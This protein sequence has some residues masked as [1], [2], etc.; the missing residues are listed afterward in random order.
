MRLTWHFRIIFILSVFALG[1]NVHAQ[2]SSGQP[3][4]LKNLIEL[5]PEAKL[6][7]EGLQTSEVLPVSYTHLTLPT[8]A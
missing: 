3:M 5:G 2:E 6:P 8:K 1:T 4:T 7:S